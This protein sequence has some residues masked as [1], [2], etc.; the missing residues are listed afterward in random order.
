MTQNKSNHSANLDSAIHAVRNDEPG[1]GELHD[2]GERVWQ[3]LQGSVAQSQMQPDV[4]RGCDDVLQL[5]PAHSAGEL[6]PQRALLIKNHLRDCL[7]CRKH[8]EGHA[9]SVLHWAPVSTVRGSNRWSGFALAAAMVL[10]VIGFFG[11]NTYF[12]IPAGARATVQSL[13]GAAYR[14]SPNG[15]RLLAVGDQLSEGEELRTAAGSHAYVKL[16]DGSVVEVNE[17]SAFAVKARGKDTT[18]ALGRGAVIVQAAKRKVGHLYVKTPDCRVAVTGTVFGVNSGVKGSR[19]SV[20][21]GTVEVDHSG[22]EDVLHSGDQVATGDNMEPVPVSEDIAWSQDLPKHLELLAQF[23]K[24]QKRLEQVQL[25]EP[26]FNSTLLA[27]MPAD[28]IF[29]ASLPNA[30]QALEDANRILQEQIQ[31]SDSLRAWWSHGDP[32]AIAKMN[33]TI[34]KVHQLSDYLG[35]E[36]VVAGFGGQKTG[37]AIVAEVHRTGLKEFLETQFTSVAKDGLTIVDPSQLDSLPA[38]SKGLIALIRPNELVFSSDRDSL[39]KVNAQ[40]DIGGNGLDR[41]EFGQRLADAYQ[42]GAGL[43][44]AADLHSMIANAHARH[45]PNTQRDVAMARSGFDDMRYLVVEH[46]ELNSV[47]DNHIVLDFAGQRQGIASWLAAPAPMGSLEFVSRNAAVA[48][49]IVGKEPQ[50]MLTDL[51]NMSDDPAK[52]QAKLAEA[53]SKLKLR[54][55]EDIAAHFGGDLV[56]A[57]DGPVLPTPAWKVVVEVHDADQLET[58]LE[59]LVASITAEAQQHGHQGADL[60][61]EDVNGQTYYSIVGRES[62][63][64]TMYY[65]FAAGYMIIGPDRATLMNTLRTRANGDSLAQSGDFKALLPKDENSNYSMIAYQNLSPILQPLLSQLSGDQAKAIQELAADSRP[66]VICGWGRDNRIEA[67]SNSRL[68]GFDW[69]ALTSLLSHGTS[70]RP[71]S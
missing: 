65:T 45:A 41:T 27:R 12:A 8:A 42:R 18:I 66:S 58:S 19:V 25:P 31:Q 34:A 39:L 32:N 52:G 24:L 70:H 30:G 7:A 44:F 36:V 29:Y 71:T 38:T 9:S 15:E 67:A 61:K 4:I 26:R 48:I 16:S 1:T 60:H 14:V 40:L 33:D 47:P 2:A 49:A 20:V 53:E 56:I 62:G 50:L 43:L 22:N 37:V 59:T 23:S 28:T 6:S 55:R 13:Q 64:K 5:L 11:Y 51:L 46:R 57:L 69:V 63:S 35:N 17:R 3:K 10:A 54:I 68:L 21:E